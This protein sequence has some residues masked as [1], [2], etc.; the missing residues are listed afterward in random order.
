[1][2]K[3]FILLMLTGSSL[4]FPTAQLFSEELPSTV[5][6]QVEV[7]ISIEDQEVIELMELLQMMELLQDFQVMTLEEEK[8]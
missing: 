4:V 2:K 1:M 3:M 5:A 6:P 8:K 7:D